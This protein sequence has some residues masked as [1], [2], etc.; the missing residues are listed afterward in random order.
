MRVSSIVESGPAPPSAD[1]E[2]FPLNE[3]MGLEEENWDGWTN[4]DMGKPLPRDG[5][6]TLLLG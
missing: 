1:W 6:P 4:I 3:P 5:S 2:V